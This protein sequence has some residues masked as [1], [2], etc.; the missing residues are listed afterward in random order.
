MTQTLALAPWGIALSQ[1]KCMKQSFRIG[2]EREDP[3]LSWLDVGLAEVLSED[4]QLV[5]PL[6]IQTSQRS[7]GLLEFL[8]RTLNGTTNILHHDF[9]LKNTDH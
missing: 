9:P 1:G 5:P 7:F 6:Y 4:R 2:G 8:L 3:G